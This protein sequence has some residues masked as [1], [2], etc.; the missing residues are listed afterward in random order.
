M[1]PRTLRIGMPPPPTGA[2][3]YAVSILRLRCDDLLG[4]NI[5]DA[6]SGDE[7]L[8]L[9][10]LHDLPV[11]QNRSGLWKKANLQNMNLTESGS[12]CLFFPRS[13]NEKE[14][15]FQFVS[16]TS[17]SAL[18]V[19]RTRKQRKARRTALYYIWLDLACLVRRENIKNSNISS[20]WAFG[21]KI[22]KKSLRKSFLS[23]LESAPENEVVSRLIDEFEDTI[24]AYRYLKHDRDGKSIDVLVNIYRS[25]R[26]KPKSYLFEEEIAA[27]G[28]IVLEYLGSRREYLNLTS[29]FRNYSQKI[30]SKYQSIYQAVRTALD[31][32]RY[33]YL[34][35][36]RAKSETQFVRIPLPV[37]VNPRPPTAPQAPPV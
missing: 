13:L 30:K 25:A 21:C 26:L 32:V 6:V 24:G 27:F 14:S 4:W 17:R 9:T 20:I 29:I 33:Y 36:Q 1:E 22:K 12:S 23:F 18:R 34:I 35:N 28:I 8:F 2:S 7:I 15:T 11:Y 3:F 5:N 19:I 10:T 37:F 31:I 16:T